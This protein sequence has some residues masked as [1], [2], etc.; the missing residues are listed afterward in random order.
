MSDQK[1]MRMYYDKTQANT[2][3]SIEDW[4]HLCSVL[5]FQMDFWMKKIDKKEDESKKDF[6][7]RV[8]Q[9]VIETTD[10][11][12]VLRLNTE[13]RVGTLNLL[14]NPETPAKVKAELR[15]NLGKLINKTI[16]SEQGTIAVFKSINPDELKKIQT[17]AIRVHLA[18]LR[19]E[20]KKAT[21]AKKMHVH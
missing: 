10:D 18:A 20:E 3:I 8:L 5:P 13:G 15:V 9:K 6:Y 1:T 7:H 2:P 11:S 21:R 17:E 4:D 14:A 16:T 19:D 12:V